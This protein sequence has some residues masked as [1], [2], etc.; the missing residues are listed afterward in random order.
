MRTLWAWQ[1]P[2]SV[3]K[4]TG[5]RSHQQLQEEQ[6]IR[7]IVDRLGLITLIAFVPLG[8]YAQ[9]L[10]EFE[11]RTDKGCLIRFSH[12]PTL[13]LSNIQ[14]SG[15]CQNGVASGNGVVS[16][17]QQGA[18]G[19]PNTLHMR[20]FLQEGRAVGVSLSWAEGSNRMFLRRPEKNDGVILERGKSSPAATSQEIDTLYGELLSQN[21]APD[22]EQLKLMARSFVQAASFSASDFLALGSTSRTPATGSTST[23]TNSTSTGA[24]EPS[25]GNAILNEQCRQEGE[26]LLNAGNRAAELAAQRQD[27]RSGL[28]AIANANQAVINLY[29]GKCRQADKRTGTIAQSSRMIM[30]VV[31][32]CR[33]AGMGSD[34]DQ[35]QRTAQASQNSAS[36]GSGGNSSSTVSGGQQGALADGRGGAAENATPMVVTS[37]DGAV[38]CIRVIQNQNGGSE[39]LNTC[40]R[41]ITANWCVVGYDCRTPPNKYSNLWNIGAGRSYPVQGARGRRIEYAACMGANVSIVESTNGNNFDCKQ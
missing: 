34:C 16:R 33:S 3:G 28:L 7:K 20:L 19:S 1:S 12:A 29:Q 37:G 27:A 25:G 18:T 6:V 35:I 38:Q 17:T 23:A 30:E 14:W 10:Q 2:P 36:S 9:T 31:R 8:A 13:R 32:M 21:M 41:T 11:Y 24:S 26:A 39:L 4:A 22:R 5:G 15:A 40:D